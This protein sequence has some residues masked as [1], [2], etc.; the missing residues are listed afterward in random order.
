MSGQVFDISEGGS[1]TARVGGAHIS[2]MLL[3]ASFEVGHSQAKD[4]RAVKPVPM[5]FGGA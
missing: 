4:R 5:W 2:L 1:G 3:G